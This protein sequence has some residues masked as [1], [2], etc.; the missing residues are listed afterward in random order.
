MDDYEATLRRLWR[1]KPGEI[2]SEDLSATP[3]FQFGLVE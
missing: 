3:V 1:E 2:E